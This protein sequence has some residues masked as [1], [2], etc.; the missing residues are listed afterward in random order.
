MKSVASSIIFELLETLDVGCGD[1]PQGDVNC[2]I[3]TYR[4]PEI[5]IWFYSKDFGSIFS[6]T[7]FVNIS[8]LC[9]SFYS[10]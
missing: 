1:N 6:P 7:A 8:T 2:D 3:H 5:L 10:R 9:P 4:N